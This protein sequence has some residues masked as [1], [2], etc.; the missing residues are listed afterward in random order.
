MAVPPTGLAAQLWAAAQPIY[1]DILEHPFLAG[2][3]DGSLP[4]PSFRQYVIQDYHYLVGFCG[5]LQRIAA[6][7][8]T[9]A[10]R[11]F[12]IES[13]D[14]VVT[15]EQA[16]H[17]G[18]L[19]SFGVSADQLGA[20][21][22]TPTTSQYIAF[23]L[24]SADSYADGVASVLACYWIYREVG[25]ELVVRGSADP[26]YQRW[27]DTYADPEFAATVDRLLAI[28]DGIG[29]RSSE[30]QRASFERLWLAGCRLEWR[31]WDSAWRLEQAG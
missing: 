4:E 12:F 16:L 31:F 18:L 28:V 19:D 13:A 10:E 2:L 26:R 11:A 23:M 9:A 14:D 7:A 15:V 3:V 5:A 27:I 29:E 22:L 21:P 24:E 6:A 25:A 17:H 1:A 8:P 20:S 30:L